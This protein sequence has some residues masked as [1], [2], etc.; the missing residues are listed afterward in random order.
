MANKTIDGITV[1]Q[2]G[3]GNGIT[4]FAVIKTITLVLVCMKL[5]GLP[6]MAGITWLTVFLP[7]LAYVSVALAL[8]AMGCLLVAVITLTNDKTFI[9]NFKESVT[10]GYKESK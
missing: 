3:G 9:E 2:I 1:R 6:V 7:L 10:H 5:V 8:I 4:P